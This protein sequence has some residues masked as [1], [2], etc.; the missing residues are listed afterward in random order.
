MRGANAAV[1]GLL[2]SALYNPVWTNT[3]RGPVD[4]ASV[5]AGF[6]LLTAFKAPPILVVALGLA[7]GMA[8]ALY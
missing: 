6:V 5:L 3:V 7:A 2:A 1:V 8:G 4:F